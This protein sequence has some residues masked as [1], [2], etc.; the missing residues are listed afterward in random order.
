MTANSVRDS[1]EYSREF[2][3]MYH[4]N[5]GVARVIIVIA[6]IV[7]LIVAVTAGITLQPKSKTAA[8]IQ[9]SPTA[10]P[11][12]NGS[13]SPAPSTSPTAIPLSTPTPTPKATGTPTAPPTT[14]PTQ[15]PT[16]QPTASPSPTPTPTASP[17]PNPTPT[18]TP[19]GDTHTV[20]YT[21]MMTGQEVDNWATSI[22]SG[23]TATLTDSMTTSNG[24]QQLAIWAESSSN[25]VNSNLWIW[26]INF[27]N[28]TFF[29][30][31]VNTG[32][33]N[34]PQGHLN[35]VNGVANVVVTSTSIEFIGTNSI[36]INTGLQHVVQ[37]RTENDGST[38]NS[39]N[40][41]ITIQ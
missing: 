27:V 22:T 23:Y 19:S 11:T 5:S 38:F 28:S 12:P 1:E 18:P 39:G 25:D 35:A 16:V 32:G 26:N 2:E 15:A 24:Q 31:W 36:T 40:L 9:S 33:G 13:S 14:Q 34:G 8:Q 3:N 29:Y 41:K 37:I 17:T 7:V 21:T 30:Y 10:S 20:D 4:S 6:V